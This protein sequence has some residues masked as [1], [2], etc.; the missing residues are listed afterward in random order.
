MQ[1]SQAC[2]LQLTTSGPA[3]FPLD[4]RDYIKAVCIATPGINRLELDPA[5]F[6]PVYA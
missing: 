3:L 5:V 6:I 2:S 1:K 4:Q